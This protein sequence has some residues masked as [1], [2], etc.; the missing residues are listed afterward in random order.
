MKK[1]KVKT[2]QKQKQKQTQIVNIN[3]GKILKKSEPKRKSQPKQYYSAQPIT[4]NA[5]PIREYIDTSLSNQLSRLDNALLARATTTPM[6]EGTPPPQNLVGPIQSNPQ[7]SENPLFQAQK[8]EPR[9]TEEV[10]VAQ[11]YLMEDLPQYVPQFDLNKKPSSIPPDIKSQQN[12]LKK[13]EALRKKEEKKAEALRLKEEKKAEKIRLNE[14]KNAEKERKKQE[15]LSKSKIDI[16]PSIKISNPVS[17]SSLTQSDISSFFN[18][19]KPIDKKKEDYMN[20]ASPGRNRIIDKP[21]TE[22]SLNDEPIQPPSISEGLGLGL[23]QPEPEVKKKTRGP[24]K[25]KTAVI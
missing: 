14:E 15:E 9:I 19:P 20:A 12:Q 16:G 11:G 25:K 13:E 24:N 7:K 21:I 17:S 2:K 1:V 3:L 10:P 6:V 4:F 5:P 22:P 23:G 8:K 18:N